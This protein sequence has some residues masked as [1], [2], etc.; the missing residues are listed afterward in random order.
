MNSQAPER[1]LSAAHPEGAVRPQPDPHLWWA[2]P[3]HHQPRPTARHLLRQDH[4]NVQGVHFSLSHN[5]WMKIVLEKLQ[6][7]TEC[8]KHLKYFDEK[9]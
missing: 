8:L 1:E 3:H 9:A 6:Y 4:I 7:N 5:H 2:H